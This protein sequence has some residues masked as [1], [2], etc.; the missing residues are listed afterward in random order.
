MSRSIGRFR[1]VRKLK[2]QKNLGRT[3]LFLSYLDY[4]DYINIL[5]IFEPIIVTNWMVGKAT[6]VLNEEGKIMIPHNEGIPCMFYCGFPVY[7]N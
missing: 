6:G 5:G 7:K 1:V 4:E 2:K 3:I